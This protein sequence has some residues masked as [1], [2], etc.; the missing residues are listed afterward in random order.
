MFMIKTFW[1]RETNRPISEQNNTP[2]TMTFF[3]EDFLSKCDQ[4]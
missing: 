3:I 2:Q 4:I 1:L